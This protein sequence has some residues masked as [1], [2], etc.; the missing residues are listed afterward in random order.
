MHPESLTNIAK[1]K[2]QLYM[3]STSSTYDFIDFTSPDYVKSRPDALDIIEKS[4]NS[5]M[6]KNSLE[7]SGHIGRPFE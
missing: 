5:F 7:N 2:T 1:K 3:S 6:D 4:S